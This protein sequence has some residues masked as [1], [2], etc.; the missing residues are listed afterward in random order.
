MSRIHALFL[1]ILAISGCDRAV[2]PDSDAPANLT[3]RLQPSGDPAAPSGVLL[4]WD[5]VTR[6]DLESYRVYS[7]A[8]TQGSFDRRGT[9]TSATFHDSGTPD[10]E[11]YVT[12]VYPGGG[13]SRSSNTIR[14]DDAN[15][16]LPAPTTL[17]S[18]SLNSAVHLTWTDNAFQTRPNG[19]RWYRVYSTSL[20]IDAVPNPLCGATWSLEGTS[21][22]PEF[23]ATALTNGVPRCF[24][25]SAESIEGFESEWSPLRGDTPRPDARNLL[26]YPYQADQLKSGFRF[27]LD[28]NADGKVGATELAN[29]VDG[30]RTDIDFWIFRG[31]GDT[32]SFVPERAGVTVALYGNA[33]IAD[34]TS[35][36][37]APTT[38]YAATAIDAVPGYG[39]VFQM[40]GGDG[41]ARFG[42]L[43][44][45]HVS[46]DYIIFD[47][48]YQTDPGNPEL[49]V[50][51][52]LARPDKGG[53]AI[54]K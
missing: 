4:T 19:F 51:A 16:R 9:T 54:P 21:V 14:I 11:Y 23:L 53:M 34:L 5:P 20:N 1:G 33:P 28:A 6:Q 13:E 30:N 45:T 8:S 32:L 37:V 42:A 31:P 43:R 40:P 39:Y 36:D 41:F 38:G 29:V 17:T 3:Y 22:S 52:G 48:S 18:L 46:R 12:A 27:W 10:R 50:A 25:V 47:W 49:I 2:S 7:R 26:M 44:V 15:L 24:G 35:I